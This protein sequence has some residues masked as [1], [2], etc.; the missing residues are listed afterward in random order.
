LPRRKTG[1]E[2]SG[3]PEHFCTRKTLGPCSGRRSGSE[4][5]H[6]RSWED[7]DAPVLRSS[8]EKH[9]IVAKTKETRRKDWLDGRQ[10]Y[11]EVLPPFLLSLAVRG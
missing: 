7:S 1:L 11:L 9:R 2:N 10:R 8:L 5:E 3:D 6:R 4:R